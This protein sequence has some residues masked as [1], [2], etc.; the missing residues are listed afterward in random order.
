MAEAVS[1]E[2][3]SKHEKEGQQRREKGERRE[4]RTRLHHASKYGMKTQLTECS[5][6]HFHALTHGY[7]LFPS[8]PTHL[9]KT[10]PPEPRQG[11]GTGE[12]F[13][14]PSL[15]RR[16]R[17]AQLQIKA[18]WT[19]GELTRRCS[20]L[21][22]SA[23]ATRANPCQESGLRRERQSAAAE[24]LHQGSSGLFVNYDCFLEVILS[25][26]IPTAYGRVSRRRCGV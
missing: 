12:Y 26:A 22:L 17:T 3:L 8:S 7:S 15:P 1:V 21:I 23:Q 2:D 13:G 20:A 18:Q 11:P 10:P 6:F 4:E 16:A 19:V 24:P 14:P 25:A 5:H 9:V